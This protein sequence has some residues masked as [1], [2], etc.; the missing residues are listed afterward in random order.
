MKRTFIKKEGVL[1]NALARYLLGERQG[2]RLM[3]IEA[4]AV[5]CG[6]SVGLTQAGLKSLEASGAVCIERRG[7]NGSYLL[8]V[9][10]TALL[11]NIDISNVVCAMPL[12]YTR[13]YEGL[14]SGLKALFEGV[15]FYYAHMRGADSRVECLLGGVYDMAVVSRLAASSYLAEGHLSAVLE[16]GPHTYVGEHRLICR[17]GRANAIR[18]VGIDGRS[19]DQKMLTRACFERRNVEYVALSYHESLARVAR[20]DIDAVVWNVVDEQVLNGL[21][22]EAR[23]LP[24]DPRLLAATE[25][26][27]LIRADDYPIK[28]LFNALVDKERLLDHQRRVIRGELEPHY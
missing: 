11:A 9:D 23:P 6:T 22:L 20:G 27:V 25:A 4:L 19:A 28:T 7:R 10:H 17:S 2:N 16:F 12:P 1:L 24:Q 26:V 21:G 13:M 5:A 18:R 15:P 3:T 8:A 14:A